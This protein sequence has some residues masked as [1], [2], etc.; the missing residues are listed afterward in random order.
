MTVAPLP[1]VSWRVPSE[2]A[3]AMVSSSGQRARKGPSP[4]RSPGSSVYSLPSALSVNSDSPG[5]ADLPR[6][7]RPLAQRPAQG[8]YRDGLCPPAGRRAQ[9]LRGRVVLV[10]DNLNTH[11]SRATRELIAARPWLMVYQ[12]PPYASELNPLV[13][14]ET[15]AGQPHQAEH[16]S[17]DSTGEDPAPADAVPA[18]PP[19]RLPGQDRARPSN[20][21]H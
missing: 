18:R 11:V 3:E 9:Q 14:P 8:L 12:L 21:H 6:A 16:R 17:A 15:V 20:P 7:R 13:E 10:W 19:R 5:P 2:P 1:N 4:P